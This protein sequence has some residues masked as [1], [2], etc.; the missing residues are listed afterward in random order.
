MTASTLE[1]V[2]DLATRSFPDGDVALDALLAAAQEV[3]GYQTTLMSQID[4]EH[5]LLRIHAVLNTDPA[6]TVPAGLQIP[7]TASPCQ[8]IASSVLPFTASNMHADADLALLPACRDMGATAYLGVPV[9]L[10]DGS[11]FGTFAAL[12]TEER[13]QT[14]EQTQWFQV[15]ARM[16]A[17]QVERQGVKQLVAQ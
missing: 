9:V 13:A 2:A 5:A 6:L 17:G 10:S 15:L 16:A 4:R 3:V 12:D 1:Q 14:T 8:H 7:L 11:F